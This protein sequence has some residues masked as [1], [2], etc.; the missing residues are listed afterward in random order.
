MAWGGQCEL[1]TVSLYNSVAW[2][3]CELVYIHRASSPSALVVLYIVTVASTLHH[4]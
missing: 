1:A 2:G 4:L 3:Q